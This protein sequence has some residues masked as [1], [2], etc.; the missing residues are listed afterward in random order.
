MIIEKRNIMKKLLFIIIAISTVSVGFSMPSSTSM[1]IDN[2]PVAL[3]THTPDFKTDNTT[4]LEKHTHS[5]QN[6]DFSD[7][8]DLGKCTIKIDMEI[9]G[10][11]IKG[12]LTLHDVSFFEC[13]AIKIAKFFS[14]VF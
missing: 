3:S 12:K 7:E 14:S 13:A 2:T 6:N 8:K 4:F 11:H 9:D 10:V 5:V 1:M